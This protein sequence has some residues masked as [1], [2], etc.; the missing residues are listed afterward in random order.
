MNSTA[1]SMITVAV[2][3]ISC[4]DVPATSAQIINVGSEVGLALT[5]AP[6]VVRLFLRILYV[7]KLGA[8]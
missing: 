7:I 1:K 2:I 4:L 5:E 8:M 3:V 6:S